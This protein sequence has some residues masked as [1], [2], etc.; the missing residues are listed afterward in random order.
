MSNF[1]RQAAVCAAITGAAFGLSL[2]PAAAETDGF[3]RQPQTRTGC[4]KSEVWGIL[5]RLKAK[6][7]ELELTAGCNGKH[8]RHSFHYRGMAMDFRAINASQAKVMSILKSDPA[9]GGLIAEHDGL[10]HVYTG[11]RGAAKT[12]VAWYGGR[13][14]KHRRA[15]ASR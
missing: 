1:A 14:F 13:H 4:I 5:N 6:V 10:I 9:I 15:Y 11:R 8:A 3:S 12:W 7:G 2:T